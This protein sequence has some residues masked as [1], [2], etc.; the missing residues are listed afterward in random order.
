MDAAAHATA[1]ALLDLRRAH[2][3]AVLPADL[4][5][6]DLDA[7][8]AA[9]VALLDLLSA[10]GGG[11]RIGWKVG[12][13]NQT[14]QERNGA[15]EPVF[16]GLLGHHAYAGEAEIPSP[17]GTGLGVEPEIA[18]R[19][20]A[21]LAGPVSQREAAA[22]VEAVAIAMEVVEKRGAPDLATNIADGILQYG[23]VLGEWHPDYD[24]LALDQSLV[25]LQVDG[26]TNGFMP[27]SEVL[28]HPLA[29]L[30]WLSA[31]ADRHGVELRPGDVILTGA[32][33]PAQHLDP[34]QMA[35]VAAEG[36]GDIRLWVD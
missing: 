23:C 12:F 16:A 30:A 17:R 5:P 21:P 7:A 36:L 10:D 15:T 11:P 13:T 6:A 29:A 18:L 9:H 3:D 27:A 25:R 24:P 28:G 14:A 20:A 2:A 26:E 33:C 19:L 1:R 34:G 31:A 8:Y 22:A 4:V 35:E 32:I